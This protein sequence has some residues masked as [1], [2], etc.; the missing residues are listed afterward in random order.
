MP[1]SVDGMYQTCCTI[2][3]FTF[4]HIILNKFSHSTIGASMKFTISIILIIKH[5]MIK[6][7]TVFKN[8]NV[9][10]LLLM[11]VIFRRTYHLYMNT[12]IKIYTI[13]KLD[14]GFKKQNSCF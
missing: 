5:Y 6:W 8:K 2:C 3:T 13:M 7:I 11:H 14:N 12:Q 4:F 1:A 10:F 9:L